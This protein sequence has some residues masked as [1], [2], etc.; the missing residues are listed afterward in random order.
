MEDLKTQASGG[1]ASKMLGERRAYEFRAVA[2][3]DADQPGFVDLLARVETGTPFTFCKINHGFWER[4]AKLE[5]LNVSRESFALYDGAELDARLGIAGSQ[6]F[7]GGMAIDVLDWMGTLP[8]IE[9]G[10]LFVPSLLPFPEADRLEGTPME[11]TDHCEELIRHFVSADH[12]NAIAESGFTGHELKVSVINGG[13]E[14]LVAALRGRHVIS[15]TNADNEA[16]VKGITCRGQSFVTIDSVSARLSRVEL[17]DALFAQINQYAHAEFPP[18]VIVSAGGAFASWLGFQVWQT[19]PYVQYLDFGGALSVFNP[20]TARSNWT[21]YYRR[22]M[23]EGIR[24]I[25]GRIYPQTDYLMG[26]TGIRSP[27]LIS[28]AEAHGV[29]RPASCDELAAPYPSSPL[30]FIENKIYDHQRLSELLS[31]SIAKNHHANGGPITN[32]LEKAVKQVA[33]LSDEREV[34]A[35]A[36]GTLALQMAAAAHSNSGRALRWVSSAF[37]FFSCG[38]GPLSSTLL[39]DCDEYG[40]LS[41][42]ALKAVPERWYDGV[43]YTNV[44]AQH[45]DWDEVANY[46]RSRGKAFIVDNATGL[47]DRPASARSS[48]APIEAVSAHHTKPWGVGEGG[49]VICS[50]AQAPRIRALVNFG[51]RHD[52]V[53]NAFG[54]NAKMSDL[55]AAAI[56]DRLERMNYWAP[57]YHSQERRMKSIAIDADRAVAPFSQLY[58]Q[59]SPRAHSPFLAPHAVDVQAAGAQGPVTLRKYYMPMRTAH[60]KNKPTPTADDLFARIF[61]LSNSP[62]MRLIPNDEIVDQVQRLIDAG[63]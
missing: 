40:R 62:E 49:F 11:R 9:N 38:I 5:R 48:D 4:L 14:R 44:F 18:V 51:D 26:N 56:L 25:K 39:V 58:R 57:Y 2:T 10:M 42:D 24:R 59:A 23:S 19:F 3:L 52:T 41:L 34:V 32:L 55:S 53:R 13:L 27:S 8:D 12:L 37:N 43:I 31:V 6:F 45:A 28:L 16:F 47:L 33:D 60:R 61:S 35:V 54:A 36:N 46:C 63:Q 21:R 29:P 22:E 7:Q 17:R 15:F 50:R 20:K 30:P 1:V